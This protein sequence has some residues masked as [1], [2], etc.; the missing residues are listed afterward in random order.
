MRSGLLCLSAA[1][2]LSACGAA[3]LQ[4]ATRAVAGGG[5]T[6][7]D[8]EGARALAALG[9][10]SEA[11]VRLLAV[12]L[13]TS[14]PAESRRAQRALLAAPLPGLSPRFD[15]L[16]Q[17]VQAGAPL[18]RSPGLR[19]LCARHLLRRGRLVEASRLLDRLPN[20]PAAA[21]LAA[22]IHVAAQRPTA[23]LRRLEQAL[24][25]ARGRLRAL[26]TLNLARLA[27]ER[28]DLKQARAHYR[29]ISKRSRWLA[30]ALQEQAWLELRAR[31]PRRVL[32]L[33][34]VLDN[35]AL[36]PVAGP[37]RELLAALA[38]TQLC[39]PGARAL[40]ARA[41]N[42]LDRL[43]KKGAV[44]LRRRSD[45]R[46]YY[47][48]A[49]ASLVAKGTARRAGL[50][51]ELQQALLADASFVEVFGLV[52]QLQRERRRLARPGTEALAAKLGGRLERRLVTAQTLAGET[53]RRLL[54]QALDELRNLRSRAEEL[55]V[56]LDRRAEQLDAVAPPAAPERRQRRGRQQRWPRTHELWLDEIPHY[57]APLRSRCRR[58]GAQPTSS[59]T[60]SAS[61]APSS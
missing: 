23:A 38:L 53:V 5:T 49:T 59:P 16:C 24:P 13:K 61:S 9:L 56:E 45:V 44:F 20:D 43:V 26:V 55:L 51:P 48:E 29:A 1:L 11:Q 10:K 22:L 31:R 12:L 39:H 25:F 2:A 14:S 28:A 46:L 50:P 8:I 58:V 6:G 21:H 32:G 37:D 40:A 19:L 41:R 33:L 18:L 30:V 54:G 57:R 42:R 36:T 60:S 3:Q 17:R 34:A 7:A 35:R 27:L 15:T 4:P 47:V 52:R